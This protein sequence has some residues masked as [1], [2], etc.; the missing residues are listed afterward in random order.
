MPTPRGTNTAV[1]GSIST[2]NTVPNVGPSRMSTHAP[3]TRPVRI[4]TNLS[5]GS[6]CTPRVAPRAVLKETLCWTGPK[7][8]RPSAV[9]FSRCQFSLNQPRESSRTSRRS[10]T[11]PGIGVTS[12]DRSGR[13][14]WPFAAYA[15]SVASLAGRHQS[16]W[17]WYHSMVSA[18]PASKSWYVGCQPSSWRSLPDSIA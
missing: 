11:S 3:K 5:H 18:S 9:I 8:G 12:S 2:V 16:S 17:A 7:S 6:V 14:H 15:A 4:E 1:C 13:H 10:T